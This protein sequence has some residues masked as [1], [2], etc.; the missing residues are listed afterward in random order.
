[1]IFHFK[2][3]FGHFK[4]FI[5]SRLFAKGQR[6]GTVLQGIMDFSTLPPQMETQEKWSHSLKTL[7]FMPR[8][9]INNKL[10]E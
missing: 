7:D 8:R 2:G 1:L 9:D 4:F 5:A 6:K 3:T 10:R